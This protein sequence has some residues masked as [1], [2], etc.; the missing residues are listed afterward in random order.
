MAE[1]AGRGHRGLRAAGRAVVGSAGAR[2]AGP[3]FLAERTTSRL[4]SL[5]LGQ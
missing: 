5:E 1:G 3:W 2:V 4:P